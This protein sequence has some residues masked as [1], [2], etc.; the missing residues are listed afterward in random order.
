MSNIKNE[1]NGAATAVVAP[2]RYD[3]SFK[4]QGVE[5]WLRGG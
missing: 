1:K 4:R 5:H 2:N 3:D